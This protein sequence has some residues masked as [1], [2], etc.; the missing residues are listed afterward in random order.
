ML[1]APISY[2]GGKQKIA[3]KIVD[4]LLKSPS[5]VYCDLC[6]GCGA[7]SV[8]LINRGIDPQRIIMLDCSPWGMFWRMV[9]EGTFDCNKFRNLLDE[10]P[11][12]TKLI[13]SYLKELSKQPADKDTVYVYLL[14]QAGSFGS[15]SIWIENNR[16]M[17][18]SFRRYWTP[19]PTSN[20]RSHVNPMMPMPNT[21]YE[22]ISLVCECMKGI[23]GYHQDINE[24][25]PP[26]TA[27]VYIDPPY[28]GT[29]LY[30]YDF[31]VLRYIKRLTQTC[32]VSE[33]KP[34]CDN[35]VLLS[36]GNKKGGIS[37]ARQKIHEEWLSCFKGNLLP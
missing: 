12:D 22:R 3:H 18:C 27:I 19:T 6:C 17:N 1:K 33:G 35:A 16:W 15:K 11:E 36:K 26:E 24:F 9:G 8:E 10:I 29:T 28:N 30:G 13:Q 31:D 2:Q 37:A 25:T 4:Y 20:R 23:S 21:L 5:A 34:L 32:F 7:I 14:L